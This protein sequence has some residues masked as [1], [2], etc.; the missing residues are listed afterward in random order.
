MAKPVT[1]MIFFLQIEQ[2]KEMVQDEIR[3]DQEVED[4]IYL[5]E[6][7]HLKEKERQKELIKQIQ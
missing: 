7:L 6:M 5:R 2:M 4:E 3:Q 1:T